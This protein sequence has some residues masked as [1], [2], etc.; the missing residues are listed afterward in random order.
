MSLGLPPLGPSMSGRD[1]HGFEPDEPASEATSGTNPSRIDAPAPTATHRSQSSSTSSSTSTAT[2]I[3]TGAPVPVADPDWAIRRDVVLKAQRLL[4]GEAPLDADLA[5]VALHTVVTLPQWP[6]N[7]PILQFYKLR[8]THKYLPTPPLRPQEPPTT[9]AP[10]ATPSASSSQA[11]PPPHP[12][13]ITTD[14]RDNWAAYVHVD[15]DRGAHRRVPPSPN[16]MLEALILATQI[17]A[18]TLLPILLDGF[19][20]ASLSHLTDPAD[21]EVRT[22]A[23]R[24]LRLRLAQHLPA[25]IERYDAECRAGLRPP[26][27]CSRRR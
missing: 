18:P 11:P 7:R 24:F 12:I 13:A 20:P 5:G 25:T 22:S 19:P 10:H 26:P 1:N 2:T 6:P 8:L 14:G 9:Q 16:A 27:A 3:A 23:A 17:T 15:P 4:A 21:N